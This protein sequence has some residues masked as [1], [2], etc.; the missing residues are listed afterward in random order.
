MSFE[1]LQKRGLAERCVRV[2]ARPATD[3]EL[4]TTHSLEHVEKIRATESAT[5][6]DPEP[7]SEAEG[8]DT[9]YPG[10]HWLDPDTFVNEHS[11]TAARLAVGGLIELCEQV[12]TGKLQNGFSLMRPPVGSARAHTFIHF[13]LACRATIAAGRAPQGSVCGTMWLPR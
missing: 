11:H 2:A 5:Y 9:V 10:C 7:D 3:E 1:L 8:D 13:S 12:V 6:P 4:L